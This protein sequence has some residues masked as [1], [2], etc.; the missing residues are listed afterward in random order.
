[1]TSQLS[2]HSQNQTLVISNK[3]NQKH[4]GGGEGRERGLREKQVG[5]S[6]NAVKAVNGSAYGMEANEPTTDHKAGV[7]QA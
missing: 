3:S 5:G 4:G 6:V 1:M 2:Q 7:R